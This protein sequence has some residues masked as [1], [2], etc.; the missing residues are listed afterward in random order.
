MPKKSNKPRRSLQPADGRPLESRLSQLPDEDFGSRVVPA[1]AG[2]VAAITPWNYPLM[3]AVCKVAP[4]LAAGCP[5]LLK[6]SPLAS[7]TCIEL[8]KLASEETEVCT[9]YLLLYP[10]GC[11]L[12]T[13]C[14]LLPCLS[15][16]SS[17]VPSV[18]ALPCLPAPI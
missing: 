6:P 13:S 16:T 11:F 17:F 3:Q 18:S 15:P 1:P 8:A 10:T 14:W 7:L 12:I 2:V 4:A 9:A 5:V